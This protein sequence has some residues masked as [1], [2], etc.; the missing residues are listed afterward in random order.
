MLT[1][2]CAFLVLAPFLAPYEMTKQHLSFAFHPPM[3]LKW[4]EGQLCYRTYQRVM[5]VR[6]LP[7]SNYLPI[8]WWVPCHKYYLLG[9]LPC[10]HKLFGGQDE[11]PFFLLGTDNLGRDFFSRLLFGGRVSLSIGCLGMLITI[12]LGCIVGC[13]AG[14]LGGWC[15][16]L[17]MRLVE[18]LMSIP[19]L[20]LLLALRASIGMQLSSMPSYVMMII[21]LACVGWTK[22]AR[23][24]R[25]MVL[26]LKMSAFV[27][28]SQAMGQST[29]LIVLKHF[30]PNLASYLLT[31]MALYV[32][33]YILY[34]AALSFLGIGIQEPSTSWGL[35]LKYTQEDLKVFTLNLW[36]LLLPGFCIALTVISFNLLGDVLRDSMDTTLNLKCKH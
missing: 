23:V 27:Q 7:Q 2:L 26:E 14:L 19:S 36:W 8:R 9:C 24:I 12:V 4:H 16:V 17:L 21:L 30:I 31:A 32:P 29:L 6:Y 13:L 15:D 1:I 25:G 5:S 10:S 11:Y 35:M 28:S 34:E 18:F 20:Y 3:A 22:S 33:S